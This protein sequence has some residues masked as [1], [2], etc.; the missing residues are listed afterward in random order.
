MHPNIALVV[1]GQ[2]KVGQEGSYPEARIRQVRGGQ[3]GWGDHVGEAV[4]RSRF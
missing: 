3:V 2:E 1:W 4:A